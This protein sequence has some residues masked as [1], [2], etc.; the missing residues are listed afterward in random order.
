M[1]AISKNFNNAP[2]VLTNNNLAEVIDLTDPD[3]KDNIKRD[4]YAAPEVVQKLLNLYNS[5]CAYCE[6][7]EPEPEVEHYRPKKRV[8]GINSIGYYWLCYEWSNL[9]PSCHDCNKQR[10]KGNHFPVE[11]V[12]QVAPCII[13]GSIDLT[14]NLLTSNALSVSEIPLLLNP[15]FPGFDPFN[16][17]KIDSNGIFEPK[18]NNGT[19][20]YRKAE[21]TIDKIRLNRDKLFTIRKR[22]IR[23][24]MKRINMILYLLLN[25][26]IA[27]TQY[28]H[29][30]LAILKEIKER[31]RITKQN[32]YWFFWNYFLKN[33]KHFITMYFKGRFR[34]GLFNTFDTLIQLI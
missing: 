8:T 25:N 7:Y 14:Q 15:E 32:E 22:E 10:S 18:P 9:L 13:L 1:R 31:T 3:H 19:L 33:F 2:T 23:Y 4:I 21:A 30:F 29:F 16:Y 26:E 12:R 11:G 6:A 5:K 28:E 27:I 17:F 20:N 34:L 24:Y